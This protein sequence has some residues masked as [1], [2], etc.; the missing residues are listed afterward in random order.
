VRGS[1]TIAF[2]HQAAEID[3]DV[4]IDVTARQ[5]DAHLPSPW[6]TSPAQYCAALARSTRVDE[7]T[8]GSWT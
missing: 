3:A 2:V 6:I 7:V 1:R 8:I 5:F 4:V